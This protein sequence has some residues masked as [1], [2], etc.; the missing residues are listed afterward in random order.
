MGWRVFCGAFDPPIPWIRIQSVASGIIFR[1][2]ETCAISGS[3]TYR[4][5]YPEG[6]VIRTT[7][8]TQEMK[9]CI[10]TLAILLLAASFSYGK[11]AKG[12][13]KGQKHPDS[14]KIFQKLDADGNGSISLAEFKASPKGQK[15]ATKAEK[16]F[17]KV[18]TDANGSVSMEEFKA[19][20]AVRHGKGGRKHKR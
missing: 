4:C 16:K 19:A 1:I 15:D 3:F 9:I 10:Q 6:A 17:K 13:G 18:D 2:A 5:G 20:C 12:S 8:Q 14:Q 7:K 11:G